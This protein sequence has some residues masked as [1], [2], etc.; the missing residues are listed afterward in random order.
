MKNKALLAVLLVAALGLGLPAAAEN[1]DLV[2]MV[3]TSESM[4]PYFDDLMNSLIQ[5]LLT[6]K[7]HRGDSFHLLSFSSSP[8]VEISLEVNSQE[9]AARAFGRILLLHPLGRYTDLAAALR[10]LHTYTKELPETNS[11]R[12]LLL[13]DGVHDPPPGSPNRGAEEARKSIAETAAAIR[14]E[15]WTVSILKVPPQPAKGETGLKSYLD[16]IA[17]VL[18]VQVAAYKSGTGTALTGLAMGFPNLVF[19][20]H[21]GKVGNRFV[22]PFRVKNNDRESAILVGLVSIQS[23]GAEL[24]EKKV[25]L[26]VPAGAE[27]ALEAPVRLPIQFPRGE[28]ARSVQLVFQDDLRISP[29]T[30]VLSFTYTGKGGLPLPRLTFLYVLYILLAAAV[31]YLLVRLFLF[32]REKLH[33]VSLSG[34]SRVAGGRAAPAQGAAAGSAR[35]TAPPSAAAKGRRR[36]PLMESSAPSARKRAR[37]TVMS[38]RRSLPKPPIQPATLPPQ[39]EMRVSLQNSHIGFRNVHRIAS[40]SSRSVGGR[41]SSYLVFLVSVPQGIAEIRNENGGYTFLPLR[42]EFFPRVSGPL[43]DCLEQDIAFTTPRGKEL[44]LRFRRWVSPL[45]EIN[46]LMRSVARED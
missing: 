32:M 30:G 33:E 35:R 6:A 27:A 24:L 23:E 46:R 13:T 15:G 42:A 1:M 28:H 41:F 37:P 22:V 18:G 17:S 3:D 19:P 25:Q 38:M 29:T 4:F 7:L 34:F 26:A 20:A 39:I 21:L 9:A 31:I 8:E 5:D 10:F 12:I 45:E 14:S 11:K 40:G 2:V 36:V 43:P 44:T 16:E